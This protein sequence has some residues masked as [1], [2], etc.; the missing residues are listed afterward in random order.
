MRLRINPAIQVDHKSSCIPVLDGFSSECIFFVS[1]AWLYLTALSIRS[2]ILFLAG[3]H[4]QPTIHCIMPCGLCV[5]W[6][7]SSKA[8]PPIRSPR[9][10]DAYSQKTSTTPLNSQQSPLESTKKLSDE[11]LNTQVNGLP[12]TD[13]LRQDGPPHLA[14][15]DDVNLQKSLQM[16]DLWDEAYKIIY[17]RDKDLAESYEHILLSRDG[18]DQDASSPVLG[19]ILPELAFALF[20]LN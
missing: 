6:K 14:K 16:R 19:S 20:G 9:V 8:T 13:R 4:Y 18:S 17:E 2:S 10:G 11:P 1:L 3:I 7:R 5:H 12:S 15:A